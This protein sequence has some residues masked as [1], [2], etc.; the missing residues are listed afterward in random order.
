MRSRI[1]DSACRR[2]IRVRSL[3]LTSTCPRSSSRP[4]TS[5]AVPDM[6]SSCPSCIQRYP[7][8]Q[9]YKEW[10][11]SRPRAIYTP[12]WIRSREYVPQRLEKS[13][14]VSRKVLPASWEPVVISVTLYKH[15]VS[16]VTKKRSSATFERALTSKCEAWPLWLVTLSFI[17]KLFEIYIDFHGDVVYR[18]MISLWT[19]Y[20]L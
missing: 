9:P 1:H 11:R 15:D 3:S 5:S 14:N 6:E 10:P 13:A 17:S 19:N 7:S 20:T 8:R 12:R 16:E 18:K 4:R 2:E